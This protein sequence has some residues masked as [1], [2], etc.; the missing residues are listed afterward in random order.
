MMIPSVPCKSLKI[1]RSYDSITSKE[2]T[3][4]LIDGRPSELTEDMGADIFIN[5]FILSRDIARFFFFDSER[6]VSLAET[7]T[8]SNRQRL[9]SAYNEGNYS[10]PLTRKCQKSALIISKLVLG[11][12]PNSC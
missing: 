12:F 4:I 6:I 7:T 5:D 1:I 9:S 11:L 3:K 8:K 2:E 10:A